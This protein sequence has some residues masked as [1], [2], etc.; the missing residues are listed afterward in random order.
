MI[1]LGSDNDFM[2][3]LLM[4]VIKFQCLWWL[5]ILKPD[6]HPRSSLLIV[7]PVVGRHAWTRLKN[8][9]NDDADVSCCDDK[10]GWK[11]NDDYDRG[12]CAPCLM[13]LL[14]KVSHKPQ[15][16]SSHSQS[17]SSPSSFNCNAIFIS[18]SKWNPKHS[19]ASLVGNKSLE[20]KCAEYSQ[21]HEEWACLGCW[22]ATNKTSIRAT[23]RNISWEREVSHLSGCN[24]NIFS[25]IS[26]L[27]DPSPII[28]FPC[29][30][31]TNSLT[32]I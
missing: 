28:G 14:A 16:P 12:G 27:S 6:S 20:H 18:N 31:V 11:N 4:A 24:N 22:C 21:Q 25:H 10:G 9:I 23:F 29:H 2:G 13:S 7:D 30:L 19:N 17:S 1:R 5:Y 32:P 3:I 15:P 8:K 26:L